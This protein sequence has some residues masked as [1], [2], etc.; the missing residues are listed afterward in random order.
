VFIVWS[1]VKATPES[2]KTRASQMEAHARPLLA[3]HVRN[4]AG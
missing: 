1:K 2:V 3:A 4:Y